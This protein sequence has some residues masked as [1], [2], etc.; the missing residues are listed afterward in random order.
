MYNQNQHLAQNAKNSFSNHAK[1]QEE[2]RHAMV[3]EQKKHELEKFE[4][5]LFYKKQEV[6]RLKTLHD[7]LAR[8]AVIKQAT[9]IKEKARVELESRKLKDIKQ[10]IT[11]LDKNIDVFLAAISEKIKN[12][13]DVLQ[14]QSR[15]LEIL[16]NKQNYLEQKKNKEILNEAPIHKS[17]HKEEII[18]IRVL[19]EFEKKKPQI[20]D[21]I[22]KKRTEIRLLEASLKNVSQQIINEEKRIEQEKKEIQ[23]TSLKEVQHKNHSKDIYDEHARLLKE[24]NEQIKKEEELVAAKEKIIQYL[25]KQK[26]SFVLMEKSRRNSLIQSIST[27]LFGVK[28]EEKE[29]KKDNNIFASNQREIAQ[30]ETSLKQ[31]S[32]EVTVLENKV[33]A[34]QTSI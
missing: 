18:N 22:E 11:E 31:F 25:E 3:R 12:E 15:E 23:K 8:E 4:T 21:E 17:I 33:K 5:Q 20:E 7:R 10:K 6:T 1:E 29:L 13:K 34:L 16:N 28:K 24:I 32:Q 30:I 27:A 2:R 26:T 19:E 14:N 9:Q